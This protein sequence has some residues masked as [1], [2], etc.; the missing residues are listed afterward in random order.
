MII[1]HESTA[2]IRVRRESEAGE[3]TS[4]LHIVYLTGFI[5]SNLRT[6]PWQ[7]KLVKMFNKCVSLQRKE[8][9]ILQ[10][11]F[12]LSN[13]FC[14]TDFN[15]CPALIHDSPYCSLHCTGEQ[16]D[17][18]TSFSKSTSHFSLQYPWQEKWGNHSN[19]LLTL[20]PG[21]PWG[22]SPPFKPAGPWKQRTAEG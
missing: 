20:G 4:D 6:I 11:V 19:W 3:L 16:I 10:R 22:P 7:K 8:N 5:R 21:G 2:N 15:L 9:D 1:T 12:K 18:P 13:T 17:C 14:R